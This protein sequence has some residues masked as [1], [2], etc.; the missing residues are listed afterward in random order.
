MELQKIINDDL[1]VE[2]IFISDMLMVEQ[3]LICYEKEV[4]KGELFD[5]IC[6]MGKWYE[7]DFLGIFE[8]CNF[9]VVE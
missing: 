1:Y 3:F 5:C 7:V 2:V 8:G 6:N 9:K 4:F